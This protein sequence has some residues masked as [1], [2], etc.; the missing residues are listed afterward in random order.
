LEAAEDEQ[1]RKKR[2]H[3]KI[4]CSMRQI[5]VLWLA[6]PSCH[7]NIPASMSRHHSP[8]DIMSKDDVK[9]LLMN[10]IET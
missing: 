8:H 6:F 2:K 9:R 7:L 1:E 4:D 10:Q 3:H 5:I